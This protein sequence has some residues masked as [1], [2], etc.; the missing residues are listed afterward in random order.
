MFGFGL[1]PDPHRLPFFAEFARLDRVE[2]R[3]PG[4]LASRSALLLRRHMT[5]RPEENPF[6]RF[7]PRFEKDLQWLQGEGLPTYHAYAFATVRQF[8]ANFE[9][10]A[11]YTKW[12][13]EN[14]RVDLGEAAE[15][16]EGIS[17]GAKA[18]ILKGARA[19]SSKKTVDFGPMFEQLESAWDRAMGILASRYAS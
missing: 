16:F 2:R 10:A 18:L 6:R 1:P 12:L 17:G 8:G 4:D 13:S 5:R 7:R 15:A 3:N 11:A 14:A 9:L 19:V